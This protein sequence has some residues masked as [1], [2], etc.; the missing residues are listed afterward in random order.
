L[1]CANPNITRAHKPGPPTRKRPLKTQE[2]NGVKFTSRVVNH[3]NNGGPDDG[4]NGR[5]SAL[6]QAATNN[7]LC[8]DSLNFGGALGF[9][10]YWN[11]VKA[12]YNGSIDAWAAAS[13]STLA[14]LG[15]NGLSGWSARA[16]E[17]AAAAKGMRSFHLLDIGVTW[18]N[19]WSRGLDF[20][21]FSSNFSDQVDAIAAAVVPKYANDESLLAWQTDNELNYMQLGLVTYLDTYAD[22]EGGPACIA[23]LQARFGS[24][25]ALNS[26]FAMYA[27]SWAGPDGVGAHLQHDKGL[28]TTAIEEVNVDWIANVSFTR[29]PTDR[30]GPRAPCTGP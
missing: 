5:E 2:Q 22:S 14:A 27:A 16:A 30:P 7:T 24:L 29:N 12:K 25:A 18:P 1:V 4:V 21:V 3:V 23:Y 15:F 13:V 10:P 26:A 11:V 19:A 6:C 20:D 8:G 28:N 17:V 9:S